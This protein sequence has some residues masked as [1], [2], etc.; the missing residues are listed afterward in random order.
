VTSAKHIYFV[1][2]AHIHGYKKIYLIKSSCQLIVMQLKP[3]IVQKYGGTSIGKLLPEITGT[4][5]PPYL[6]TH[7]VA[8][9]CS[10]RSGTTKSSGTT[11]LLLEAIRIATSN[12]PCHEDLCAITERIKNEHLVAAENAVGKDASEHLRTVRLEITKDCARLQQLLDATAMLAEISDH[13]TDRVLA[14]G[15]T[16]S[17]RIVAASLQ[18]KVS[19]NYTSGYKN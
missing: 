5:I 8:V 6:Q 9:V 19:N 11:S 13:T 18:S 7:R 15:E 2:E 14:I 16:L 10:A 1:D 17:C 4:I 3:W 12:E